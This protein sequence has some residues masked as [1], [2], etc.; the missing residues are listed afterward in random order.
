MSTAKEEALSLINELSDD[1]S[2][3]EI[4]YHLYVK[5]KIEHGLADVE[6]GRVATHD[7]VVSR[8]AKWTDS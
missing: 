3:E 5:Q 1:A 8:M 7:E 2:W 6:A 4:Q